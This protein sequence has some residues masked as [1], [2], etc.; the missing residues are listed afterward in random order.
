M[1]N[2]ERLQTRRNLRRYNITLR[3]KNFPD[4]PIGSV[5]FFDFLKKNKY[6]II[7]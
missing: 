1:Q 4:A 6:R 7:S 3:L 2:Y 5:P